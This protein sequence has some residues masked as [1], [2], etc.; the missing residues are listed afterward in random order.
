MVRAASPEEAMSSA[1]QAARL[2]DEGLDP[3]ATDSLGHGLVGQLGMLVR[4]SHAAGLHLMKRLLAAGANPLINDEP[5]G[6]WVNHHHSSLLTMGVLSHLAKQER[7]GQGVRDKYEGCVL[8]YLAWHDPGLAANMLEEDI[9]ND[10]DEMIFP[11]SMIA[12]PRP[13]DQATPLHVLWRRGVDR[14]QSNEIHNRWEM[15]R[16]LLDRGADPMIADGQGVRAAEQVE[17]WVQAGGALPA[18]ETWGRIQAPLQ[19]ERLDRHMAHNSQPGRALR[20]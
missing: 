8:H 10:P 17:Q 14:E 15:T 16:L 12:M 4:G 9:Y 2:L 13:L 11:Q 5:L 3:N 18:G 1:H 7:A 19:S 6:K 20:L